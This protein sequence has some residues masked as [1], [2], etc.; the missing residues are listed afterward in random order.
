MIDLFRQPFLSSLQKDVSQT[1]SLD[2]HKALL[3]EHQSEFKVYVHTRCSSET[4]MYKRFYFL[5]IAIYVLHNIRS[6]IADRYQESH[7][8]YFRFCSKMIEDTHRFISIDIKTLHFQKECPAWMAT[9]QEL[10]AFPLC[11]WN[12]QRAD[13]MELVVGLYQADAI[14]LLD[15]SRPSFAHF[16]KEMGSVFGI[17]FNHPHD[18]MQRIINRKKNKT[19]FLSRLISAILGKF[20]N[21]NR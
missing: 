21:V 13:L 7:E 9:E 19:P 1:D 16:A 10:T 6:D 3:Q 5:Q 4:V 18:E 12:A 14:R 8:D 20:E 15:G 2:S 17:T 11:Q